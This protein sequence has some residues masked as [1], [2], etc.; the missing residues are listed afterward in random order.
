MSRWVGITANWPVLNPPEMVHGRVSTEQE[1]R[2]AA[3]V[4]VT[5]TVAMERLFGDEDALDKEVN[6]SAQQGPNTA[7]RSW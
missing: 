6:R 4:V 1:P 3:P 2:S 7:G 5:N